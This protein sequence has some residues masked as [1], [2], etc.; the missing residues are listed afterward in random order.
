MLPALQVFTLLDMHQQLTAVLPGLQLVLEES[1][2]VGGVGCRS[3]CWGGGWLPS[4]QNSS[5][6]LHQKKTTK[7]IAHI[8]AS[9]LLLTTRP[10]FPSPLSHQTT[11][12]RPA[13]P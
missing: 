1:Q 13:T 12:S 8:P 3:D 6:P 9:V 7:P 5:H 2:Q 11:P 10:P 4:Q